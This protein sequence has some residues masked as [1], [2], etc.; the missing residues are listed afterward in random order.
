MSR[1][2]YEQKNNLS[3]GKE[4]KNAGRGVKARGE[5]EPKLKYRYKQSKIRKQCVLGRQSHSICK[6]LNLE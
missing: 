5:V 3:A 6:L 1:E 4:W 2:E